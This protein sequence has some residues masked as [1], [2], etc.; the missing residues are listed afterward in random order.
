MESLSCFLS[1]GLGWLF[2]LV[3][4]VTCSSLVGVVLPR[5]SGKTT[6][7]KNLKSRDN[8]IMV[9]LD[10]TIF[11][12]LSSEDA[13]RVEAMRDSGKAESVK[14]VLYPKARQYIEGLKQAFKFTR[15]ILVCS[16]VEML[17]YVGV[18]EDDIHAFVASTD[19]QS[20]I[21]QRVDDVEERKLIDASRTAILLSLKAKR[22]N[23]FGSFEDLSKL[24]CQIAD[25]IP[26]L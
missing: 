9:D 1:T 18:K 6:L 26:R 20:L 14:L 25:L 22:I 5:H 17:R 23:A 7:C 13:K 15:I 4:R 19:M 21:T 24:V 2:K 12:E 8:S 11:M 16:D 3:K 10:E